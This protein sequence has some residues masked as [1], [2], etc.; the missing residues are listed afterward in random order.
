ML[1]VAAVVALT[2]CEAGSGRDA[3]TPGATATSAPQAGGPATVPAPSPQAPRTAPSEAMSEASAAP[4]TE[5]SALTPAG[6]D[7]VAGFIS[8]NGPA[9]H[10]ATG[11][12]NG[13][14][15]D[16]VIVATTR[17]HTTRIVVG[18]WDGA[19]YVRRTDEG[20]PAGSLDA[21]IVQDFNGRPGAEIVT[22]QSVGE[23]G[24]SLS[25][26]GGRRHR[27]VRQVASGG[28]WDG[29]HTYGISGATIAPGRIT[30]TCDGSP[31]P[32]ESWM[33]DVYEWADGAWTYTETV[34]AEQE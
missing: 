21:L 27:L 24:A 11:D 8:A 19:A 14:G 16:D 13:D 7:D 18:F 33:S 15:L 5:P 20:G 9:D 28:C 4:T 34:A 6:E 3:P 17:D 23:A 2:G 31:L 22:E 29:F 30:A 26:W 25:V 10:T 1:V 32:P 12:V